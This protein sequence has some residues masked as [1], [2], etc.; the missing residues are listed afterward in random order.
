M[1]NLTLGIIF[2]L[3]CLS[4]S[5]Q[6]FTE[7]SEKS[8]ENDKIRKAS[9]FIFRAS[10]GFFWTIS[11]DLDLKAQSNSSYTTSPYISNSYM[12]YLIGGTALYRIGFFK[13]GISAEFFNGYSTYSS[14][15]Q[16]GGDAKNYSGIRYNGRLEFTGGYENA[17][18]G[19]F[20][21]G[22]MLPLN[23]V[24]QNIKTP[25]TYSF[26][27]CYSGKVKDNLWIYIGYTLARM[28]VLK[29]YVSGSYY[30]DIFKGTVTIIPGYYR[31]NVYS[32]QIKIGLEFKTNKKLVK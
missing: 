27:L 18:G 12:G 14:D 32:G 21:I 31:S 1:K 5:A 20:E 2:I 29:A 8:N 6:Y 7:M 3:S 26:E 11:Y 9:H 4:T 16:I 10:P 23:Y 15:T 22:S 13:P 17:F 25:L 24:G 28:D 19:A 30:D